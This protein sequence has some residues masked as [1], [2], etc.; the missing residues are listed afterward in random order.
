[1]EAPLLGGERGEIG[2]GQPNRDRHRREYMGER[3]ERP[4]VCRTL[5]QATSVALN[6]NDRKKR[7]KLVLR[8]AVALIVLA[9]ILTLRPRLAAPDRWAPGSR[10]GHLDDTPFDGTPDALVFGGSGTLASI[11]RGP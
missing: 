6:T 11:D 1:L 8:R 5:P 10:V 3:S 9:T 4:A 7:I 2:C